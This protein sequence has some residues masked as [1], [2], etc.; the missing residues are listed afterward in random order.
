VAEK[1]PPKYRFWP[2]RPPG[3]VDG[4]YVQTRWLRPY[5]P[6]L[7]RVL[8]CVLLLG[9]LGLILQV[10]LLTTFHAADHVT[11]AIRIV[12]TLALLTGLGTVFS[13]CYLS[14]LWVTDHKVRILR[15]LSTAAWTWDEV[16]DVRTVAGPT[17]LL[18]TPLAVPGNRVLL[19][20]TDGR[21]IETPVS[22][23]SPDFLGRPQAYAMAADAVEGWL[24]LAH[25]RR[26]K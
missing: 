17:R 20:L 12:V 11:L 25:R 5:R 4:A 15:P 16:A 23:R 7:I 18:G 26:T 19:V 1:P 21:D 8:T 9:V 14:G 2:E 24:Q 10:A 22:D 3:P 6:G 13:R